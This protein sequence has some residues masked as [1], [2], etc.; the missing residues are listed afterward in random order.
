ME[1]RATLQAWAAD[2]TAAP[3]AVLAAINEH[4]RRLSQP[5]LLLE[6]PDALLAYVLSKLPARSLGIA[7]R[8]C[9]ATRRAF[10]AAMQMRAQLLGLA[11]TTAMA[12][13]R[14]LHFA[15]VDSRLPPVAAP[16]VVSQA[17]VLYAG[18]I[19]T[20]R[21][22]KDVYGNYLF[23]PTNEIDLI[24]DYTFSFEFY[25]ME[26]TFTEDAALPG[27]WR[28][29]RTATGAS[30]RLHSLTPSFNLSDDQRSQLS[31]L[32]QQA[33]DGTSQEFEELF[34]AGQMDGGGKY[35]PFICA[36]L[37]VHCRRTNEFRVLLDR[38]WDTL[39]G[40][41]LT[42]VNGCGFTHFKEDVTRP[43]KDTFTTKGEYDDEILMDIQST[44]QLQIAVLTDLRA[45]ETHLYAYPGQDP[46]PRTPEIDLLHY[47]SRW[48]P[49]ERPGL[50][51]A[52]LIDDDEVP[53]LR[54]VARLIDGCFDRPHTY[55]P[56]CTP[57]TIA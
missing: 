38:E 25:L 51:T 15:E 27:G 11:T 9:R 3:P 21:P 44:F 40:E 6:L 49:F 34:Q 43:Y 56:F 16:P 33:Q 45:A 24:R 26:A 18:T 29:Q 13:T 7:L 32:F 12:T 1:L 14:D 30:V 48:F 42:V 10:A 20:S 8:T 35:G 50:W 22:R 52:L 36:K 41:A 4:V 37:F 23:G 53:A 17:D 28:V 2:P 5:C 19:F 47:E 57:R 39:D 55:R 31:E 54:E 46:E